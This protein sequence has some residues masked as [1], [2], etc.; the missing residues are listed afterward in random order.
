VF[1]EQF[2]EK[3]I[4]ERLISIDTNSYINQLTAR[5]QKSQKIPSVSLFDLD[6]RGNLA[7]KK[8]LEESKEAIVKRKLI[9]NK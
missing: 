3:T 8:Q 1:K 9:E 5:T 4:K 2:Y 7:S 6:K